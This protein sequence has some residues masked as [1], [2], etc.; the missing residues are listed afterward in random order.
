MA[1]VSSPDCTRHLVVMQRQ[2]FVCAHPAQPGPFSSAAATRDKHSTTATA[3]AAR[4][5]P[6]DFES[7]AIGL[8]AS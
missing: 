6:G 4:D 7:Q 5:R 2:L 1:S 8:D 3:A